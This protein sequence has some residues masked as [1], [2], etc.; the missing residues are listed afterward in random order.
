MAAP[1][2]RASRSRLI[3]AATGLLAAAAAASCAAPL[4]PSIEKMQT[5]A[6][7]QQVAARAR[8]GFAYSTLLVGDI[9]GE[10][11]PGANVQS[12]RD[13]LWHAM[14]TS[15]QN[16]GIFRAV[17]TTGKADYR[18]DGVIVSHKELTGSIQA[19]S[20]TL[21][22]RYKL[23]ETTTSSV[24]WRETI[25]SHYDA[26]LGSGASTTM[27]AGTILLGPGAVVVSDISGANE[28]AVRDNLTRLIDKLEALSIAR[29]KG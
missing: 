12:L 8:G 26:Q 21:V 2:F 19:T 5:S 25:A 22:V 7:P 6:S 23:T 13:A 28:G 11:E 4:A 17:M 20:A 9:G 27:A 10:T 29:G 15:L 24:I 16:S 14:T 1:R 18:L 3:V